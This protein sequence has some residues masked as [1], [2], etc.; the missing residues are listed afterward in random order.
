MRA[1]CV[2]LAFNLQKHLKNSGKTLYI[3]NRTKDKPEVKKLLDAGAT[4]VDSPKGLTLAFVSI[5]SNEPVQ[6][7]DKG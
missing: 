6:L 7:G 5:E 1:I 4:W 2:G 3:T